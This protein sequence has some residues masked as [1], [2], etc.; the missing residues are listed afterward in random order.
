MLYP[1]ELTGLTAFREGNDTKVAL[2]RVERRNA[3]WLART[4]EGQPGSSFLRRRENRVPTACPRPLGT[5]FDICDDPRGPHGSQQ[6]AKPQVRDLSPLEAPSDAG[7]VE[8]PRW[9]EKRESLLHE[10]LADDAI[11]LFLEAIE[12]K[13]RTDPVAQQLEGRGCLIVRSLNGC[14]RHSDS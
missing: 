6:A 5:R 3:G 13:V 11:D 8:P 4:R 14:H 12:R 10:I 7:Q 2:N 1:T 9:R